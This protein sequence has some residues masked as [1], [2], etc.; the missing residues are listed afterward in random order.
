MLKS[1][2]LPSL[3]AALMAGA[4]L[5]AVPVAAQAPLAMPENPTS[6]GRSPGD[7][8]SAQQVMLAARPA[9]VISG[10]SDWEDGFATLM[11]S[12]G[13]LRTVMD[14]AG[15]RPAGKPLAV[16]LET[17]DQGFRYQAMIPLEAAPASGVVLGAPVILGQTP[18]GKTMKFEHRNAYDDIDSTYEAITAYLDEKGIEAQPIF[19]EEY[20][21]E[22]RSSD[23]TGLL[24][25]IFVFVK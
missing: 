23:D 3:R 7:A 13:S 15:L 12:F 18:E 9:V 16:F 5:V 21:N 19:V 2:L 10:T 4:V 25:D 14:R 17:D 8:S 1:F 22:P 11:K 20:A 24:V 6:D